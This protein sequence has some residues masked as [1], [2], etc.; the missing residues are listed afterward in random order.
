M[1]IGTRLKCV[2]FQSNVW[3]IGDVIECRVDDDFNVDNYFWMAMDCLVALIRTNIFIIMIDCFSLSI[4]L[5]FLYIFFFFF[6]YFSFLLKRARGSHSEKKNNSQMKKKKSFKIKWKKN[7]HDKKKKKLFVMLRN[8]FSS[9][10]IVI[11]RAW[12]TQL[13][14]S[15]CSQNDHSLSLLVSIERKHF[16]ILFIFSFYAF[17]KTTIYYSL[18]T[19]LTLNYSTSYFSFHPVNDILSYFS[20]HSLFFLIHTSFSFFSFS[21]SL[22]IRSPS[23]ICNSYF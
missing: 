12:Q 23:L 8:G 3:S 19:Y 9:R 20:T 5:F 2:L 18:F 4:F 10:W 21:Y 14:S 6:F 22:C 13:C 17:L 15:S 1:R 11:P 16:W 7:V